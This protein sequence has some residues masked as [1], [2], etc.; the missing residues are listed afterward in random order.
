MQSYKDRIAAYLRNEKAAIGLPMPP[1][2]FILLNLFTLGAFAQV[3][4]YHNFQKDQHHQK[5]AQLMAFVKCLFL[6]IT[7]ISLLNYLDE[8]AKQLGSVLKIPK[9]LIASCYLLSLVVYGYSIFMTETLPSSLRLT[10]WLCCE[11]VQ[12]FMLVFVQIEINRINEEL[13]PS[14]NLDRY[15]M[16]W[17]KYFAGIV[18]S[19]LFLASNMVA[20]IILEALVPDIR[21]NEAQRSNP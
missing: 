15:K 20:S 2:S 3:W 13:R 10:V 7:L 6:P 17:R 4:A 8:S 19:F 14:V 18:L 5:H 11:F 16:N 12:L 9:N 1:K 21:R